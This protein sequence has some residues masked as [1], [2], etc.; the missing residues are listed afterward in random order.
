MPRSGV[1]A[2]SGTTSSGGSTCTGGV[3]AASAGGGVV[4]RAAC[5]RRRRGGRC[6]CGCRRGSRCGR[7]RRRRCGR[8]RLGGRRAS[9]GRGWRALRDCWARHAL[10]SGL[11]AHRG[12]G[13]RQPRRRQH[14]GLLPHDRRG[15]LVAALLD[16]Q[17]SGGDPGDRE[18]CGAEGAGA[19]GRQDERVAASGELSEPGR[20]LEPER[21]AALRHRRVELGPQR[22]ARAEEEHLDGSRRRADALRDL[23]VREPGELAEQEDL[24]LLGRQRDECAPNSFGVL[25]NELGR[26]GALDIERLLAGPPQRGAEAP[27]AHVLRDREQPRTRRPWTRATQNCPVGVDEAACVTSS[28]SSAFPSARSAAR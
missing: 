22:S 18:H 26:R 2:G 3:S 14:P 7:R 20:K 16:V 15:T 25:R 8:R 28:A 27:P 21:A 23:A 6:G 5:G 4:A 10:R 19:P 17:R 24:T 9:R 12:A 13:C 11:P 1:A